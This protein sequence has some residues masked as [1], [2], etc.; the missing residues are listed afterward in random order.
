MALFHSCHRLLDLLRHQGC[1]GIVIAV[2]VMDRLLHSACKRL[3]RVRHHF[4]YMPELSED[5]GVVDVIAQCCDWNI[6]MSCRSHRIPSSIQWALRPWGDAGVTKDAHH[7]VRSVRGNADDLHN[8]LDEFLVQVV[9]FTDK[10]SDVEALRCFWEF[11]DVP[12]TVLDVFIMVDPYFDGTRLH[13]N[14][15]MASH[16]QGWRHVK[17]CVLLCL[18]WLDW[19]DTRWLRSGRS[20]RY[21]MRSILVGLDALVSVCLAD[22]RCSHLH[23]SRH[24]SKSTFTVRRFFAVAAVAS[25]PPE[26]LHAKGMA[27]D[28]F[29]RFGAEYRQEVLQQ[30]DRIA[31][32]PRCIRLGR[33]LRMGGVAVLVPAGRCCRMRLHG[34]GGVP[35]LLRRALLLDAGGH[36]GQLA[37]ASGPRPR[38]HLRR[39]FVEDPALAGN[40]F[41]GVGPARRLRASAGR[42]LYSECSRAV[43][44]KAHPYSEQT[45]LHRAGLHELRAMFTPDQEGKAMD[46]L[47][48]KIQ[49]L[50]AR[51][52]GRVTGGTCA[53]RRLPSRRRRISRVVRRRWC[54]RCEMPCGNMRG[55]TPPWGQRGRWSSR[56]APG[57]QGITY[58]KG[59]HH[60]LCSGGLA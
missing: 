6:H 59:V 51:C 11:L 7:V 21:Y 30:L 19:S 1:E 12:K 14:K 17:M 41:R 35:H 31:G 55:A 60:R 25:L 22:P 46:R 32:F 50:D 26:A 48:E 56:S 34:A 49:D 28:R 39:D 2:Y 40:A 36:T 5:G 24:A 37:G 43:L 44:A 10:T 45:L 58:P 13:V 52:P 4:A 18:R 9:S 57:C 29:L 47:R 27:D 38:R 54:R 20:A 33:A 53:C 23:L 8:H 42:R 3:F 16:P 15:N